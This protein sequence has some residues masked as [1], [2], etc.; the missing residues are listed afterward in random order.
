VDFDPICRQH[1]RLTEIFE[2]FPRVFC[3]PKSR[4]N[5]NGGKQTTLSWG[6]TTFSWG[7]TS[8]SWGET[9]WGE[10]DLGRNDRNSYKPP[11]AF[12]VN[13]VSTV[14][15]LFWS[16]RNNFKLGRNNFKLRRNDFELGRND[17]KL[18]RNNF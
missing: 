10:T 18:G 11:T 2:T 9:T 4:I 13:R 3:F 1:V 14:L 5:E 8:P 16:G 7:E 17:F 15:V 12:G 6:K